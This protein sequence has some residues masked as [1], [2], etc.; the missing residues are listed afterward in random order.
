MGLP[1]PGQ[2]F[3]EPV[4][5]QGLPLGRR[6]TCLVAI[7]GY[8]L[9]GSGFRQTKALSLNIHLYREAGRQPELVMANSAHHPQAVTSLR[10]K[11]TVTS[12]R[13]HRR[14]DPG[15]SLSRRERF[16]PVVRARVPQG[17]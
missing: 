15:E 4:L 5:P 11:T 6:R 1:P 8:R 2:F 13:G 16:A 7:A 17:T 9:S 12:V 3:L 10:T 14:T